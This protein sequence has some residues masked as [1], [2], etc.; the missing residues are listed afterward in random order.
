M[1][2]D[3][4]VY[5]IIYNS[6]SSEGDTVNVIMLQP[7]I[8]PYSEKYDMLKKRGWNILVLWECDINNNISV[9]L[10]NYLIMVT[11]HKLW[12]LPETMT[13]WKICKLF[14]FMD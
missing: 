8:D 5:I 4:I 6:Y 13:Y 9:Q 10:I 1:S 2:D 14:Q 11:L 3:T 12:F 7:N